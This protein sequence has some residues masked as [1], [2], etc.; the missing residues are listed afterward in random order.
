MDITYTW[1]LKKIQ[2]RNTDNLNDVIVQTR[3]E[4]VGT[5]NQTDADG[6]LITGTFTGATPF[7]PQTIDPDNFTAYEN[8]TNEQVL[9]WIKSVV[10]DDYEQHVNKQIAKQ[11]DQKINLSDEIENPFE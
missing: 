7:N 3:W 10:V 8:L 2:K 11:I 5:V 1:T 9:G 6:N 4:K